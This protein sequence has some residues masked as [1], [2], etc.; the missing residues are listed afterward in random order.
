MSET[1]QSFKGQLLL[2]SGQL[3]GSFFH[4]TVVLIC[5]HDHEGAFGLVINR[6]TEN[7]VADSLIADLPEALK[8]ETLYLGG[9]VQPTALSYLHT[10]A[11]IPNADVMPNLELGHSLE[12]LV[13]L[14]E[15]FSPTQQ[16]RLF[17]GYAGWSPGQLE[18]EIQR[19]AWVI[20]PASLDLVFH[21]DS[22][23]LW[24][25]ILRA[26]GDWRYRL[27][28]NLPDDLTWN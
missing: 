11:F 21:A 25:R 12:T 27:L 7:K 14:G 4:R 24:R 6:P 8:E 13:E 1:F 10:D 3:A 23:S 15:S 22:R 5:S 26:K 19:K 17:A 28:A 20:H 18:D 16:I 9:P 2:D